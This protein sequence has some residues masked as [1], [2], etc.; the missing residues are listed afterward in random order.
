VSRLPE[1]W[2]RLSLAARV[3]REIRRLDFA[4]DVVE[5]PEWRA[6]GLAVAWRGRTP[7]VTRLHSGAQH[8]FPMIGWHNIDSR[9]AIVVEKRAITASHL[10]ISTRANL[11]SVAASLGAAM[12]PSRAITLPVPQPA[13]A[14]L[15]QGE[16][17]IVFVGRLERAKGPDLLIAAASRVL[18]EVPD[19][20][21]IFLGADTDGS[22]VGSYQGWMR[23]Q[24]ERAGVAHAVEFLGHRPRDE[25]VEQTR[26][27]WVCA[28]PS[29]L[30]T[31]GYGAAEAAALGRP[32]VVSRIAPFL[33][34]FAPNGAAQFADVDDVEGWA[35]QLVGLLRSPDRGAKAGLAGR[36]RVFQHCAPAA[37]ASQTLEAY[38]EAVGLRN[39]VR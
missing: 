2:E 32:V 22:A 38:G 21:F 17:R 15:P 7:V 11:E 4:P 8:I 36:E 20:R 39:G 25:V 28:F 10:V 34:L 35:T 1:T 24:A 5:T 23:S 18:H 6:E 16:P 31:F 29:R 9:L 3:A 19:A 26:R 37:V 27:A 33:D 13:L 12:P 14:P 30:E